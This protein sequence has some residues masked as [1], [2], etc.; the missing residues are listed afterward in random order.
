MA[1][2]LTRRGVTALVDVRLNALSRKHGFSKKS[3]AEGLAGYG[4]TYLHRPQLGNPCDEKSEPHC[5]R[6]QAENEFRRPPSI[7]CVASVRT[8]VAIT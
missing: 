8:T 1:T 6:H 3:L 5:H 2:E 7:R 4:I